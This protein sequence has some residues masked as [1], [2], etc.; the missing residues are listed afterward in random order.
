[1]VKTWKKFK[2]NIEKIKN[3]L[4]NSP[5]LNIREFKIGGLIKHDLAIVCIDGL[6]S[7]MQLTTA[8]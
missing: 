3:D 6:V 2:N 1:M 4:G 7:R 5:D 8:F